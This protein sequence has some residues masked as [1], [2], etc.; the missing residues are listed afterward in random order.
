MVTEWLE[1]RAREGLPEVSVRVVSIDPGGRVFLTCFD[2]QTGEYIELGP[3]RPGCGGQG[4][5]DDWAGDLDA[6]KKRA[7]IHDARA[8]AAK[9]RG[10]APGVRI[11]ESKAKRARRRFKHKRAHMHRLTARWLVENY[12]VI[13]IG[14]LDLHGIRRKINAATGTRRAFGPQ[15]ARRLDNLAHAQ[16]EAALVNAARLKGCVVVY[17]SERGTTKTCGLCLHVDENVGARK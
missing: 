10:D 8:K 5:G 4:V 2:A 9:E 7:C 13:L 16:F 3:T 17:A 11:E 15:A 6:E 1:Q 12:D 14:E